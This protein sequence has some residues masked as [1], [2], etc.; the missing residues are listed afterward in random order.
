MLNQKPAVGPTAL[1]VPT[2]AVAYVRMSTEHQQY[3]PAN[4]MAA[5]RQYADV[6]S[7]MIRR[8]Y[9]DEGVSGLDV[10]KRAGLRKLDPG[11]R[12]A[13]RSIQLLGSKR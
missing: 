4:Q 6:H 13:P 10:T 1:A 12:Q 2:R 11:R 7:M 8:V 9:T 5:I 3:S